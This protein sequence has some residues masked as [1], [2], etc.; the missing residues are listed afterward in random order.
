MKYIK[1]SVLFAIVVLLFVLGNQT[2]A[3]ANVVNEEA[4]KQFHQ[5]EILQSVCTL[6]LLSETF[7][8]QFV[9]ENKKQNSNLSF[10]SSEEAI[11]FFRSNFPN[12]LSRQDHN[13]CEKVSKLLFPFHFFW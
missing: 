1:N 4:S 6:P 12:F 7:S 9:K 2:Q 11:T 13:R 3:V 8:F 5:T 10:F